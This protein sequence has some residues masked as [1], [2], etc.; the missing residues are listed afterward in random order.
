VISGPPFLPYLQ[1]HEKKKFK[2]KQA[3]LLKTKIQNIIKVFE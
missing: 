3:W 2:I 1:K